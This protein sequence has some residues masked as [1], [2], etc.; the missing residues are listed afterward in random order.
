MLLEHHGWLLSLHEVCGFE[1]GHVS[2]GPV[3]P[4]QKM[5]LSRTPNLVYAAY[6]PSPGHKHHIIVCNYLCLYTHT[7]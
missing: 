5:H 4:R 6:S 3:L 7:Q 2:P 1:M